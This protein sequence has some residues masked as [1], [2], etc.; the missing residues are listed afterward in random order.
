MTM[1]HRAFGRTL[2]VAALAAAG[3]LA[4][5]TPLPPQELLD[6]RT[7]YDHASKSPATELAPA[8]LDTAKQSLAKAEGAK[9][10]HPSKAA[11]KPV[12]KAA[13][14]TTKP[15]AKKRSA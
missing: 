11:G 6:A 7:A 14:K 5:S 13:K 2:S 9:E 1:T 4:C 8:Q 10:R 15:A 12:K 3:A